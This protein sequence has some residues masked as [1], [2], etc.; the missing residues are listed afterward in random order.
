[1]LHQSIM[2]M[3]EQE[4]YEYKNNKTDFVLELLNISMI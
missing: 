4:T 2:I 3:R 1:M